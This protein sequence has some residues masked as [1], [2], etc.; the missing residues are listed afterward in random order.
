MHCALLKRYC[1]NPTHFPRAIQ[2]ACGIRAPGKIFLTQPI[3][4]TAVMMGMRVGVAGSKSTDVMQKYFR[5]SSAYSA[6]I[7]RFAGE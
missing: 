7:L 2:V 1:A 6:G 5:F 3:L 4:L